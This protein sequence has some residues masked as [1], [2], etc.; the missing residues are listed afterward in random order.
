MQPGQRFFAPGMSQARP[1][2]RWQPP[3]RGQGTGNEELLLL[4][5]YRN[6]L[7][8]SVIIQNDEHKAMNYLE[9]I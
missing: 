8:S 4:T 2:P 3:L 5:S 6:F 9:T 7:N 1:T